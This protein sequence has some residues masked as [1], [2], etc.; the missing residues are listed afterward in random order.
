MAVRYILALVPW[1]RNKITT[2]G[3]EAKAGLAA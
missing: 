2:K 3:N 1:L